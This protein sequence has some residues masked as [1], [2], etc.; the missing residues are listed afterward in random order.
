M[1]CFD[2]GERLFSLLGLHDDLAMMRK[3]QKREIEIS[4]RVASG[5]VAGKQ[6]DGITPCVNTA[7]LPCSNIS[8]SSSLVVALPAA[9]DNRNVAVLE[10][11][12]KIEKL[13]E[14]H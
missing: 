4:S 10:S 1:P 8:S 6:E 11:T 3:K 5:I 2:I 9:K 12:A 7:E 13:I 14:T